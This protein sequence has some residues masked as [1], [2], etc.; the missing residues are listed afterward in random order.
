MPISYFDQNSQTVAHFF[1]QNCTMWVPFSRITCVCV[2]KF[3]ANSIPGFTNIPY[4]SIMTLKCFFSTVNSHTLIIWA[5][6][7][8]NWSF[9]T[10]SGQPQNRNW[11]HG[12]TKTC[13]IPL[14][15]SI[16]LANEMIWTLKQFGR[17]PNPCP[18]HILNII[19]R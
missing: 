2:T 9:S 18:C 5:Q 6:L 4:K 8:Q 11:C 17:K 1:I 15:V 7:G 16:N 3:H 13:G 10:K 14:P 19:A 12:I